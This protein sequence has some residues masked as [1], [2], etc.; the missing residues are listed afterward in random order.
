MNKNQEISNEALARMA[1]ARLLGSKDHIPDK[2]AGR[3]FVEDFHGIIEDLEKSGANLSRFRVP[4][5]AMVFG[6]GERCRS[7]FL[8]AK[9]GGL[10]NLFQVSGEK[11]KTT[12][13]F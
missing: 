5:E 7:E 13:W 2:T 6:E 3:E 1:Y 8:R 4:R 12:D 9:I 11:G 10:L